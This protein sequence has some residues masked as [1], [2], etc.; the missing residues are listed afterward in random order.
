MDVA[1]DPGFSSDFFEVAFVQDTDTKVLTEVGL[2]VAHSSLE[3]GQIY[4]DF[5][6]SCGALLRGEGTFLKCAGLKP[7]AGYCIE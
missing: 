6:S 4:P 5:F 7:S 3:P 2:K 1:Y